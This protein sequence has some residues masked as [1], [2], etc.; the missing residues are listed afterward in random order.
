[1]PFFNS[2]LFFFTRSNPI[3]IPLSSR[4][5]IILFHLDFDIKRLPLHSSSSL[6]S[7][8]MVFFYSI[9]SSHLTQAALSF[10]SVSDT[11][12]PASIFRLPSP[13]RRQLKRFQLC[14][15]FKSREQ[16]SVQTHLHVLDICS[17]SH[18]R[19]YGNPVDAFR[20]MFNE[21]F[22]CGHAFSNQRNIPFDCSAE[23][24]ISLI[25]RK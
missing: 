21:K 22:D 19:T 13:V 9:A 23:I 17:F 11:F 14:D 18:R 16:Q 25:F 3:L 8:F 2:V 4:M 15:F 24:W 6:R 7:L 10:I 12:T 20:D 1:M 5:V